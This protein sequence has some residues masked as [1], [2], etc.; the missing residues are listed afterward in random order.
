MPAT[1]SISRRGARFEIG[2][3][4]EP[5]RFKVRIEPNMRE[6]NGTPCASW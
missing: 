4:A 1:R 3:A 5:S 6:R 2:A